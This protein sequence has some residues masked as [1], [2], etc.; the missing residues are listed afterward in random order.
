LKLENQLCE[1]EV[2]KN[3]KHAA[4]KLLMVKEWVD[5]TLEEMVTMITIAQ[6]H[7]G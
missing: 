5:M 6:Q 1:G 4:D 3:L 7:G 2:K